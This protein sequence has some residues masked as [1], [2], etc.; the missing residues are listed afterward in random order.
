MYC[1]AV[2]RFFFE[3]LQKITTREIAELKTPITN[4]QRRA[5]I[6]M[7]DVFGVNNTIDA[8]AGGDILKYADVL[9]MDYN[10][11]FLKLKRSKLEGIYH[12]NYQKI[13]EEKSKS[14]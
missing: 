1:A 8:L 3:Q 4:E 12:K 10:T 7:F 11:V 5:G 2:C 14:K 6:E 9:K 13:M